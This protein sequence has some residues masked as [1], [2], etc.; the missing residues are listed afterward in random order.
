MTHWHDRQPIF[1]Q[2]ADQIT[3]QILQGAW[4]EGEALPSVRSISADMKINHLTVMKGY[5]LLV[6]EGLV[7]K[8]R[9][10]GM[11]VAQGAIQQL[12]SA[13]KARFLEQQIPQIADTLQRLDMSV[14]ELVQQ[15]NPH[16]K[17]DQ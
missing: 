8:K 5:Q 4:K 16:M 2:L 9:G 17:G 15:L 3:Q 6:D 1:R 12:R 7:E 14:D 11:F 13:E 10:Q